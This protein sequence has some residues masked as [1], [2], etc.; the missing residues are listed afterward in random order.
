M[1]LNSSLSPD[2][3]HQRRACLQRLISLSECRALPL[4]RAGGQGRGVA[5]AQLRDLPILLLKVLLGQRIELCAVFLFDGGA[6]AVELLD[7]VEP[8]NAIV[9][10]GVGRLEAILR[11][12]Q[13]RARKGSRKPSFGFSSLLVVFPLSSS[14]FFFFLF[15]SFLF[16]L[17]TK[18]IPHR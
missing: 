8:G 13:R 17:I 11:V 18:I 9:D 14:S 16:P 7:L 12:C 6:I 10:P 15:F 3:M 4:Q 5:N 1:S 2:A